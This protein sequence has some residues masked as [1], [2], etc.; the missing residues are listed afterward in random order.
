MYTR[1]ERKEF[2]KMIAQELF[3]FIKESNGGDTKETIELVVEL[4]GNLRNDPDKYIMELDNCLEEFANDNEVCSICGEELNLK[5]YQQE[6]EYHGS[7]CFEEM[8]DKYCPK[9]GYI[10]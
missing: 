4:L 8:G 3:D 1:Y 5:T 2:I 10:D 9:H 6:S 7:P